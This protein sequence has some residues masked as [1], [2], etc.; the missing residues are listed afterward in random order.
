MSNLLLFTV[1]GKERENFKSSADENGLTDYLGYRPVFCTKIDENS[2]SETWFRIWA[3]SPRC[4]EEIIVFSM[5]EENCIPMNLVDWSNKCLCKKPDPETV[6]SVLNA[7]LPEATDYLVKEIPE[8]ALRIPV[9]GLYYTTEFFESVLRDA[10]NAPE[11][12]IS[13]A[14]EALEVFQLQSHNLLSSGAFKYEGKQAKEDVAAMYFAIRVSGIIPFLWSLFTEN[15][16]NPGLLAV[17]VTDFVGTPSYVRAQDIL[18][19]WDEMI[20][21]NKEFSLD[22][23]HEMKDE[24]IKTLNL[25]AEKHMELYAKGKK[26]GRNDKCFCGSDKKFKACHAK[27]TMDELIRMQ[28]M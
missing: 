8:D 7:S 17:N 24:F 16:V 15:N 19:E 28:N 2:L 13:Y 18:G 27:I 20:Y 10:Y 14:K 6:K 11:Y 5:P 3:A 1:Q 26:I 12:V 25:F 4:P 23:Y 21:A 9:V 22:R